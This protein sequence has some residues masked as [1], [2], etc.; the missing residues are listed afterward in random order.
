MICEE[1]GVLKGS[2]YFFFTPPHGNV[3]ILLLLYFGVR[4]LFL[5]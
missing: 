1:K 5:Y 3:R 2:E 4:A